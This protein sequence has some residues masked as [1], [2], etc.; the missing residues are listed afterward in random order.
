MHRGFKW[1][2]FVHN[3][4]RVVDDYRPKQSTITLCTNVLKCW[5]SL[6]IECSASTLFHSF[7]KGCDTVYVL[8]AGESTPCAC[9]ILKLCYGSRVKSPT[10]K[11]ANW[12]LTNK[13]CR[14]LGYSPSWKVANKRS[15][16]HGNSSEKFLHDTFLRVFKLQN[17]NVKF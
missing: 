7:F 4:I 5:C 17:K 11:V 13:E 12:K 3:M 9:A 6:V 1:S 14:Q 15:R 2:Q 10:W 16:Q 8:Q